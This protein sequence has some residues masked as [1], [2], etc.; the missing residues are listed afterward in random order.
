MEAMQNKEATMKRGIFMVCLLIGM[1]MVTAL[2]GCKIISASPDPKTVVEMQSG[3]KKLFKVVGPMNTS[4]MY[5]EWSVKRMGV[6]GG[7]ERALTGANEFLFEADPNGEKTNRIIITCKVYSYELYKGGGPAEHWELDWVLKDQKS[8]EVRIHKNTTPVW[9]GDY[10]IIDSTDM[11]LLDG[12]TDVTGSLVINADIENMESLSKLKTIGGGLYISGNKYIKDL[13][14]F[15]NITSVGEA[16]NIC[17]NDAL[18]SLSGIKNIKFGGGLR[19]SG[20]DA[21]TN[22]SGLESI[23]SVGGD[24]DISSNNSLTSLSSL[25]NIT[26]IK[27]RL[28]IAVNSALTVLGMTGLQSVSTDFTIFGNQLLCKSLAEELRNQV[29]IGNHINIFGNKDCTGF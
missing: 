1:V 27:G 6:E 18:T 7:Y 3:E 5:S 29:T 13:S 21:L 8:W 16:L 22:L 12:Y 20:N 24:L 9:Q 28:Y 4:T 25:E 11:Q 23:T 14:A 17:D 26:S 15:A 19:I 2:S 10:C